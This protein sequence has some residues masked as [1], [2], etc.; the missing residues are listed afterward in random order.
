[1]PQGGMLDVMERSAIKVLKRRGLTNVDI[2]SAL[3]SHRPRITTVL[4][5]PV[6]VTGCETERR[7][8]RVAY[9][10]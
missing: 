4:E 5:G 10:D 8:R 6:E 3:G 7:R 1:V 9:A 2:G